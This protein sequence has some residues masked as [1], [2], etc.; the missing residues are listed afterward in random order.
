MAIELTAD[1]GVP[2]TG[3]IS[4][5]ATWPYRATFI[6]SGSEELLLNKSET[7]QAEDD[8]PWNHPQVPELGSSRGILR[9]GDVSDSIFALDVSRFF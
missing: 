8:N 5:N 3:C 7:V 2:V 1:A 4:A 9:A 6:H